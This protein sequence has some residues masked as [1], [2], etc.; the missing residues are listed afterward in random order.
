M[1]RLTTLW[2]Q[3]IQ[4]WR[5]HYE[6]EEFLFGNAAEL[7]FAAYRAIQKREPNFVDYDSARLEPIRVPSGRQVL[8]LLGATH[9][10]PQQP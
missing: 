8:G 2:V 6:V 9:A 4:Y 5:D 1:R 7:L 3:D 10:A